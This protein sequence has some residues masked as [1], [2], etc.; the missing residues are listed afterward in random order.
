M[1]PTWTTR[2]NYDLYWSNDWYLKK[3]DLVFVFPIT[4]NV[5]HKKYSTSFLAQDLSSGKMHPGS[6]LIQQGRAISKFR[7]G[8]KI[9]RLKV[10]KLK[11]VK[12][13]LTIFLYKNTPLEENPEGDNGK[14]PSGS[15][16]IL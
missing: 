6:I 10:T 1:F 16:K 15:K 3:S 5:K 11:E 13:K 8:R 12:N 9:A 7:L 2:L 14:T 4:S